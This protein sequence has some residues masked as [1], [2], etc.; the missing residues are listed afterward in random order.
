M[1][2]RTERTLENIPVGS[3]G[4]IPIDGCQELGG[5]VN[6]YL[7]KWRKEAVAKTK[8]DV[9]F[10]DYQKETY[11][12]D[13]KVPRFGSGEAKGI[14]NESVRGKDIYL[15]VDVCNYSLTYSLSGHTNHMSPDDHFQNLKRVIA[16][17]GGKARRINVIMPFLYESRQHKRSSRE[18]LDCALALQELVR[19][20]VDNI[21]TFDAHDPRVQNAIPLSGFETVRPTYQFIKGLLQNVPDLK[22]DSEHMMAISP[23]EGATGRA[24]YLANVLGL[25]MGM[26]YKRRDYTRIVD[27]RNP[28]VAH[29][30]LGSSVEGKDVIIIDDMICSGDS[31]LDVAKQLKAR[32]ANRIFAAATFGLFTNGMKK[33]DEAYEQGIIHGILTTNLI[34]QTPEL[35]SKPYYINCDLSKYIALIIDTL[36][37]D[38]S[39]SSIL[40]P[41]ERI[42]NVVKKYRNGEKI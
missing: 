23:D 22:I 28:I 27:G 25:D 7:V 12:I 15:M 31:I 18:S 34:Y 42:Q 6:D 40:S 4:M 38:G 33:F 41:N 29:E 32:K 3:L 11:I 5:K 39:I 26:F 24:I 30:F 17:I 20:G 35:L 13:A 1:L 2:H 16:A 36:N 21:I 14:I 10:H 19:M 8:D 9:V 37:H